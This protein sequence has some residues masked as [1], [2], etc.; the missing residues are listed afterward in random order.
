MEEY[1][2]ELPKLRW[3]MDSLFTRNLKARDE[4][5]TK[6]GTLKSGRIRYVIEFRL[7][8]VHWRIFMEGELTNLAH[9]W[10]G[11]EVEAKEA[12][13]VW[14]NDHLE[15]PIFKARQSPIEV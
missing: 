7:V 12:V 3:C 14:R 15:M 9:G 11:N 13:E 1:Q 6:S 8:R 10:V 4:W 2:K 5:R